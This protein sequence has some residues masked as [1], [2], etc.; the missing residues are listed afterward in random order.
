MYSLQA[1]SV[2]LLGPQPKR[3]NLFPHF[4]ERKYNSFIESS[5]WVPRSWLRD[6]DSSVSDVYGRSSQEI[7]GE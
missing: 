6:K 3:N 4:I 2:T 5:S 7:L 1:K